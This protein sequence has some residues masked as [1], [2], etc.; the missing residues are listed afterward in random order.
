MLPSSKPSKCLHTRIY[1]CISIYI[2]NQFP[3]SSD[4]TSP[5]LIRAL[6]SFPPAVLFLFRPILQGE[7]AS[8]TMVNL[9]W[10]L[11][12]QHLI[13]L[14][15]RPTWR[16]FSHTHSVKWV[17]RASLMQPHSNL[18]YLCSPAVASYPSVLLKHLASS[19]VSTFMVR[20]MLIPYLGKP[21]PQ[22]TS[23]F[24]NQVEVCL[25]HESFPKSINQKWFLSPLKSHRSSYISFVPSHSALQHGYRCSHVLPFM[26]FKYWI[27]P[28][29][30]TTVLFRE[31]EQVREWVNKSCSIIKSSFYIKFRVDCLSLHHLVLL[32]LYLVPLPSHLV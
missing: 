21:F 8:T 31:S 12:L 28:W 23:S 11:M 1:V 2:Y 22:T 32:E 29:V 18:S 30:L 24:K 20:P 4:F 16:L 19:C 17:L 26:E 15:D 25:L 6:S 10:S 13:V 3:N 5:F 27:L 9:P 7:I 14:K